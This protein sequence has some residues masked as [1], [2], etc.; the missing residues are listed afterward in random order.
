MKLKVVLTKTAT[1]FR[2][3]CWV[4]PLGKIRC[5]EGLILKT[6]SF[7]L[8]SSVL[9]IF[10]LTK[11]LSTNIFIF[12]YLPLNFAPLICSQKQYFCWAWRKNT[13]WRKTRGWWRIIYRR[14][15]TKLWDRRRESALKRT[16]A[17]ASILWHGKF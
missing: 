4:F 2:P 10:I 14:N 12:H 16:W 5:E 7:P 6:P 8:A 9:F 13:L 15:I 17:F 1:R 11:L 3:Q